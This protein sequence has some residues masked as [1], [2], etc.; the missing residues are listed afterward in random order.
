MVRGR[1]APL[2][3]EGKAKG[4]EREV[5]RGGRA[6]RRSHGGERPMGTAAY[7][8]N[9]SKGKAV[10]GDWPEGAASCR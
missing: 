4:K 1:W 2:P 7:G 5:E 9:G 10:N 8:G 3:M 6:G